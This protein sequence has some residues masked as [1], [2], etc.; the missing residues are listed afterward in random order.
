MLEQGAE[1]Y[2]VGLWDYCICRSFKTME[3]CLPVVTEFN[4]KSLKKIYLLKDN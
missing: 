3:K 2:E 4:G 1:E